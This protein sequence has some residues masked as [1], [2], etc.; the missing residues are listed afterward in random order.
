MHPHW[1]DDVLGL[2][3]KQ[4]RSPAESR[5]AFTL[6]ASMDLA[7]TIVGTALA[8]LASKMIRLHLLR[9]KENLCLRKIDTHQPFP[10]VMRS[11]LS[12]RTSQVMC[13]SLMS[14]GNNCPEFHVGVGKLLR[15]YF[16]DQM[17]LTARNQ[18]A[19]VIRLTAVA[20]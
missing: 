8:R 20:R 4:D 16:R 1:R 7:A 12:Y 11:A 9:T 15:H 13:S 10:A 14:R 6:V 18:R 17:L 2:R 19:L 3:T 5:P